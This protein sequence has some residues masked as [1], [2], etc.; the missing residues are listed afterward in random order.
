MW[1]IIFINCYIIIIIFIIIISPA[2]LDHL[3]VQYNCQ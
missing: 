2:D 3:H 1:L